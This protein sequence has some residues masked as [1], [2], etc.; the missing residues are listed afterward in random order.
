VRL[1]RAWLLAASA[2]F[3]GAEHASAQGDD[4]SEA[5]FRAVAEFFQLPRSEVSILS[6]WRLPAEEIPVVLFIA[7]RAGVSAEA[8]VALR[9]SGQGWQALSRRY[10]I[11]ASH[12]YVPLPEGVSAGRLEEAYTRYRATPPSSWPSVTLGDREIL[13]L[14]NLRLLAQVLHLAPETVLRQAGSG[15]WDTI[16]ARLLGGRTR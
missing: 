9:R 10:R 1:S 13:D 7:R 2:C 12:L 15:T 8:L 6:D 11:D 14:V 5:Y 16:Y 4:P 3:M